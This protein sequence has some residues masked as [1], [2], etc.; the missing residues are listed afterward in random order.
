M[1]VILGCIETHLKIRVAQPALVVSRHCRV[2][3]DDDGPQSCKQYAACMGIIILMD[4]RLP[5]LFFVCYEHSS[6]ISGGT[7]AAAMQPIIW[8]TFD[9]SN[10]AALSAGY[11][12]IPQ[13]SESNGVHGVPNS[14]NHETRCGLL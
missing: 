6:R 10:R 11:L 9:G 3:C 1:D 4:L 8:G 2:F 5:Y 13:R 14:N 7:G 12:V